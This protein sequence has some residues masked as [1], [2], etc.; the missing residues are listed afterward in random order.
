[1]RRTVGGS[2]VALVALAACTAAMLP[3]RAH[4]TGATPALVLVLPV[5]VAVSLAG[6]LSGAGIAGCGFLVYDWFFVRPYSTLEV[7]KPQDLTALAVYLVVALVLA[8]IIAARQTASAIAVSREDL[9]GRLLVV[10]EYLIAEQ[11]L[12][13]LLSVVADTVHQTFTTRW[14]VVLLPRDGAL[15]ITSTAGSLTDAERAAVVV[16]EGVPQSLALMGDQGDVS[17]V[18]LTTLQRPVGMLVVAG[19]ILT[20]FERR[21][22]GAFANQAALAIER[23]QL[24]ELAVRSELLE[25][26]DQWRS[27]LV[28]AVSHDLRT[29]LA[30]IKAAVGTLRDPRVTLSSGDTEELLAMVERESDQLSRLVANLL[31]MARIESGALR[32]HSEPRTVRELVDAGVT[33]AHPMLDEHVVR[34]EVSDDLPLVDVDTVLLAQVL[35]NLLANAAQHAPEGSTITVAA[36]DVGAEVV[37]SVSDQGSGVPESERERIFHMV[38]RTA[39]SGRAGLGL[40]ISTAFVGAHGG[41]LVVTDAPGGGAEFSFRVPVADLEVQR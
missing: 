15:E 10:S 1:V 14:V 40:A 8:R 27:A 30:A 18:A 38:D 7:S 26:V 31:D 29:P 33:A 22:L 23:K 37:L 17:R 41:R 35:A 20:P 2:A 36:R 4:L 9:I 11:S 34:L 21:V 32:L 25:Q 13:R 3:L 12:D 16:E 19:A 39:G 24:Q 6:F 28:G 5:L